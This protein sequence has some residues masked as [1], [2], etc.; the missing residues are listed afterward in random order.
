MKFYKAGD[1]TKEGLNRHQIDSRSIF[2]EIPLKV[3]NSNLVHAFLYELRENSAVTCEFDRL[4][5]SQHG[6]VA[7]DLKALGEAVHEYAQ[8]QG[9]YQFYQRSMARQKNQT[10]RTALAAP[11]RLD[12]FLI[13]HAMRQLCNE[14]G[15]QSNAAYTRLFVTENPSQAKQ[16]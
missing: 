11:S 12:I 9:R 15:N 3:H 7:G 6:M 8:E 13:T 5:M 16:Q 14:V 10:D 1:Q 4:D 2:E